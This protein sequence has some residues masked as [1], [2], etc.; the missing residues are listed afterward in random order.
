MAQLRLAGTSGDHLVQPPAQSR[1]LRA[2]LQ[3]CFELFPRM[4]MG[5]TGA[6]STYC[7]PEML[8]GGIKTGCSLW[9]CGQ[10]KM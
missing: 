5:V 4:N 6:E 2:F 7:V 3:S 8:S 1:L 9:F 10:G